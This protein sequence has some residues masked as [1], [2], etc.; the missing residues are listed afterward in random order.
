[1]KYKKLIALGV[2]DL[3]LVGF[4]TYTFTLAEKAAHKVDATSEAF[5]TSTLTKTKAIPNDGSNP[6]SWSVLENLQ[7][8]S[9]YL[10]TNRGWKAVTTGNVSSNAGVNVTQGVKNIRIVE[11]DYMFQ[12]AISYSNMVSVASQKFYNGQKAFIRNGSCSSLDD[13]TFGDQVSTVEYSYIYQK[14]GFLPNQLNS[15]Y[16]GEESILDTSKVILQPDGNYLISVD[17]DL[18]YGPINSRREVVTNGG[19]EG[20]PTY[21][22]V[23]AD[24]TITPEWKVLQ[25]DTHDKYVLNKNIGLGVIAASCDSYL[26]ETFEYGASI[27]LDTVN[28]FKSHFNDVTSDVVIENKEKT[29]LDYLQNMTNLVSK[30]TILDVKVDGD[31]NYLNGQ[32]EFDLMNKG[33]V[34]L[35]LDEK[36]FIRYYN[37]RLKTSLNGLNLSF[38]EKFIT[39]L[40]TLLPEGGTS[41]EL[42]LASI[43]VSKFVGEDF[44]VQEMIDQLMTSFKLR[45]EDN[46]AIV[47]LGVN[48]HG[49]YLN[50]D[51]KFDKESMDLIDIKA[52]LGYNDVLVD[53]SLASSPNFNGDKFSSDKINYHE[54]KN[55]MWVIDSV[56]DIVGYE[57]YEIDTSYT[58]K[59]LD[60][61]IVGQ[62]TKN[63]DVNFDLNFARTNKPN[64]KKKLSFVK[65][66]KVY[67]LGYGNLKVQAN[68]DNLVSVLKDLLSVYQDST[69]INSID[70]STIIEGIDHAFEMVDTLEVDE[71][72]K[73]KFSVTDDNKNNYTVYVDR[74]ENNNLV[75]SLENPG[76]SLLVKEFDGEINL[77]L[78]ETKVLDEDDLSKVASLGLDLRS[79]LNEKVLSSEIN[80]SINE[81]EIKTDIIGNIKLDNEKYL[82]QLKANKD[83]DLSLTIYG[84]GKYAYVTCIY[85]Q[86]DINFKLEQDDAISLYHSTYE[87]LNQYYGEEFTSKIDE[88]KDLMTNSQN[89]LTIESFANFI[90]YLIDSNIE[91]DVSISDQ[92]DVLVFDY[93]GEYG[94]GQATFKEDKEI[95]KYII[96]G[97]YED[98]FNGNLIINHEKLDYV[99]DENIYFTPINNVKNASWAVEAVHD[100]SSFKGYSLVGDTSYKDINFNLEF[101]YDYKK[102]IK[103]TINIVCEGYN[104][105]LIITKI[106]NSYYLELGNIKLTC[107]Q[108]SLDKYLEKIM[109]LSSKEEN[110]SKVDQDKLITSTKEII[111]QHTLLVESLS[112]DK[113]N[114]QF[115]TTIVLDKK[116]Y[117]LS[118]G[119]ENGLY[120]LSCKK[121]SSYLTSLKLSEYTNEVTLNENNYLSSEEVEVLI[122]YLTNIYDEGKDKVF[123]IDLNAAL[124]IEGIKLSLNGQVNLNNSVASS[125]FVVSYKEHEVKVNAYVLD[126]ASYLDFEY[127]GLS[128]GF[129][130]SKTDIDSLIK[131]GTSIALDLIDEQKAKEI[132]FE[133]IESIIKKILK[134]SYEDEVRI[135]KVNEKFNFIY[136]DNVISLSNK[137]FEGKVAGNTFVASISELKDASFKPND[138]IYYAPINGLTNVKGY[139]DY[140]KE[141][142]EYKGY[143]LVG[144]VSY[145]DYT[146]NVESHIDSSLNEKT[147][148]TITYLDKDH[149]LYVDYIDERAYITFGGISLSCTKDKASS[150]I[151]ELISLIPEDKASSLEVKE[152]VKEFLDNHNDLLKSIA[153]NENGIK[154]TGKYDENEY[155]LD[156]V[157]VDDGFKFLSSNN[158]YEVNLILTNED[159]SL[160]RREEN[161][162]DE[163]DIDQVISYVKDIYSSVKDMNFSALINVN[164]KIDDVPCVLE[165]R[166]STL[167]NEYKVDLST[168]VSLKDGEE[169]VKAIINVN[170]TSSYLTLYYDNHVYGFKFD[171]TDFETLIKD[172][173]A[174]YKDITN[175]ELEFNSSDLDVIPYLNKFLSNSY[176]NDASIDLNNDKLTISYKEDVISLSK[177]NDNYLLDADIEG[178]KVNILLDNIDVDFNVDN[179]VKYVDVD[180]LDNALS[181][182][183]YVKDI[184]NY[185]G[186]ELVGSASYKG[187]NLDYRVDIDSK[188]NV[189]TNIVLRN[190][191]ER[192][193]INIEYFENV[194]YLEVGNI[195]V[196]CSKDDLLEVLAK[197]LKLFNIELKGFSI[198]ETLNIVEKLNIEL[199]SFKV[200]ENDLMLSV[201]YNEK[202]FNGQITFEKDSINVTTDALDT[203]S[204]KINEFKEDLKHES[205][206]VYLSY[207]DISELY[208]LGKEVYDLYQSKALGLH[209]SAVDKTNKYFSSLTGDITLNSLN[210]MNFDIKL[211]GNYNITLNATIV[212]E[213]AYVKAQYISKGQ[214]NESG[215]KL[216]DNI[217][218]LDFAF[219][220]NSFK[221]TVLKSVGI[222]NTAYDLGIDVSTF[223][224][225]SLMDSLTEEKI[226]EYINLGLDGDYLSKVFI[227][228]DNHVT[229]VKYDTYS[230]FIKKN[231]DNNL[232]ISTDIDSYSVSVEV[233][234]DAKVVEADNDTK[235]VDIDVEKEFSYITKYALDIASYQGYNIHADFDY[236]NV[237]YDL[238]LAIDEDFSLYADVVITITNGE[239]KE[240][241]HIKVFFKD[242]IISLIYG[243]VSCQI[244]KDN[245]KGLIKD[246]TGLLAL[247]STSEESVNDVVTYI[248]DY[249]SALKFKDEQVIWADLHLLG[250]SYKI[251]LKLAEDEGINKGYKFIINDSLNTIEV[252]GLITENKDKVVVEEAS[253]L[254]EKAI[255]EIIKLANEAKKIYSNKQFY[256][257]SNLD[258]DIDNSTSYHINAQIRGDFVDHTKQV[259][260]LH[261][262]VTDNN[263]NGAN[264]IYGDFH[265]END[266]VYVNAK[267]GEYMD[268]KVKFARTDVYKAVNTLLDKLEASPFAD[269]NY[270]MNQD[271]MDLINKILTRLDPASQVD[272]PIGN[273]TKPKANSVG[274]IFDYVEKIVSLDIEHLLGLTFENNK[275]KINYGNPSFVNAQIT[276]DDEGHITVAGNGSYDNMTIRNGNLKVL[277]YVKRSFKDEGYTYMEEVVPL[278]EGVMNTINTRKYDGGGTINASILFVNVEA[279]IEALKMEVDEHGNPY[280]YIKLKIPNI[281]KITKG[282]GVFTK[283]VKS[284][285]HPIIFFDKDGKVYISRTLNYKTNVPT[286][287]Y[288]HYDSMKEFGDDLINAIVWMGYFNEDVLN[289]LMSSKSTQQE[290]NILKSYTHNGS[291]Y[292]L[293]LGME[294][295]TD[296]VSSAN[297]TFNL[298]DKE[299]ST[300]EGTK[301]EKF[302]NSVSG[303]AKVYVNLTFNLELNSI[304]TVDYTG[305]PTP[306]SMRNNNTL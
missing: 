179:N 125:S 256:V 112:F 295:L 124:D 40:L 56:K 66:G 228:I 77:N 105:D 76:V 239:K 29:A 104:H 148:L 237:N 233:L 227:N 81:E 183:D 1:M 193:N 180:G 114:P 85:N 8:A 133:E 24:I 274:E 164:A 36:Y 252:N 42:D 197:T 216:G 230:F 49:I 119:G 152:V 236:K 68:E 221:E 250:S 162:F 116:P 34:Q 39:H 4:S 188:Y 106:D 7:Y 22:L 161:Y 266:M 135:E 200:N 185:K 177:V 45:Y 14:Y 226:I 192:I 182:I 272:D 178:Y 143:S 281:L 285:I 62:V 30:D 137:T 271:V 140:Y 138:K 145:L 151:L 222:L 174:I 286:T 47:N 58:Y 225:S 302:L 191:N 306:E 117:L 38:D 208:D 207:D 132:N 12:Q 238:D 166:I 212:G 129:K 146:F 297:I 187:L 173:K 144:Q 199:D 201:L 261:A 21:S 244:D 204:L 127:E 61:K 59:D 160:V 153:L 83:L 149:I 232:V 194:V 202:A 249:V 102:N 91:Y 268:I 300:S 158:K 211:E 139:L 290:A 291:S 67:Y 123:S 89:N 74:D 71:K 223:D 84:D 37:N 253:Y 175:K 299:V 170:K 110:L 94:L 203:F 213:K 245:I 111:S 3:G 109:E 206:K 142:K 99:L 93:D 289:L 75:T 6:S 25:I 224:S 53:L 72:G 231:D 258:L 276:H 270:V 304:G 50:G 263:K 103:T 269:G 169:L 63:L 101:L 65:K 60:F 154:L 33:L 96:T 254:D 217:Y 147:I 52:N 279:N 17:L 97:N 265:F 35:N 176:E 167:N 73:V 157:K 15:Y 150:Y 118:L 210:A 16:Y 241:H 82:I 130:V 209:V 28:F 298:V 229:E 219:T 243:G 69:E 196:S 44:N 251:N 86:I 240:P 205:T 303:D 189:K 190:P 259:Y 27:D 165:T 23:H 264:V 43:D 273:I 41:Q 107:N 51:I 159:V 2:A 214:V 115:V 5:D 128:Y 284:D 55:A 260:D 246:I 195:N 220:Y 70:P 92:D 257:E 141:I 242:D 120:E 134:T 122:S 78:D 292:T 121:D 305:M 10:D 98:K 90:Y 277:D 46:T 163:D 247:D 155:V 31:K 215:V 108:D 267:Y 79:S 136:L 156:L 80:L 13:A 172:Y 168:K 288:I 294:C 100:I 48:Y 20:F 278:A 171:T 301:I 283:E 88:I 181:Y 186:F 19:A 275:I 57:G 87:V 95:G 234:K 32:L 296:K 287:E 54:M 282:S 126:D 131:E 11:N 18:E 198:K 113:E 64:D 184:I 293:G 218:E 235:Y 255:N 26:T 280:G 9:Y 262:E 248:T